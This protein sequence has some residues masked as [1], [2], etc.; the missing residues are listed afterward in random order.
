[1]WRER[2]VEA[3][4]AAALEDADTRDDVVRVVLSVL[5]RVDARAS[6]RDIA[7]GDILL[8]RRRGNGC[9]VVVV[10]VVVV[11][12][13]A[14]RVGVGTEN[15]E[16]LINWIPISLP[17]DRGLKPMIAPRIGMCTGADRGNQLHYV[18]GPRCK[19][20][21]QG[22]GLHRF[23]SGRPP[24]ARHFPRFSGFVERCGDRVQQ[25]SALL[26]RRLGSRGVLQRRTAIASLRQLFVLFL[27]L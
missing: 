12:A 11:V 23:A 2:A 6:A 4:A 10:V 27:L 15:E 14:G 25:L 1:L 8:K 5:G 21:R 3:V 19:H 18:V 9:L 16:P 20:G 13:V 22:P 26:S 7:D 24:V 17:S